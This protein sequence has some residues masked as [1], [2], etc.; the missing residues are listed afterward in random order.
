[1][2]IL[3]IGYLVFDAPW[4]FL[5]EAF[6]YEEPSLSETIEDL[7]TGFIIYSL[8][9]VPEKKVF[10]L[11]SLTPDDISFDI[12]KLLLFKGL[13][14]Y[15]E[16]NNKTFISVKCGS[17]ILKLMLQNGNSYLLK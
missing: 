1:M 2:K 5:I 12:G 6:Y 3:G 9:K 7:R 17:K 13:Y 11:H 4:K 16:K 15:K 8:V 10:S 14:Y